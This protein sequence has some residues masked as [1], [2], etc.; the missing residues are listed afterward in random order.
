MSS[1]NK[2]RIILRSHDHALLDRS[3][4]KICEIAKLN[5]AKIIGPIPVPTHMRSYYVLRSPH[6][7]KK[8]GE[9]FSEEIHKRIVDVDNCTP[10]TM[11][12][13]MNLNLSAGVDVRVKY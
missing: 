8:S 13:L 12:A 2:I 9:H 1:S 11:S 4:L 3:V 6:I 10:Q 5:N 7:D